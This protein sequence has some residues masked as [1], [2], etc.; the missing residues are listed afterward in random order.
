MKTNLTKLIVSFAALL[1]ILSMQTSCK[2]NHQS[3]LVNSKRDMVL[4][5][6]QPGEKWLDG[7][8]IGN[9]YMGAMVFGRVQNERIALNETSF[10]SGRPHDYNNPDAAKYFAPIRDLVFDGKYKDAEKND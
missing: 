10:W 9:G 8:P 7:L 5:Y 4:W 3:S 1:I 6:N 2:S